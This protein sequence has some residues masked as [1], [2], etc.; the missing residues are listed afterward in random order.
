MFF[1]YT[2]VII[3]IILRKSGLSREE[4]NREKSSQ[5]LSLKKKSSLGTPYCLRSASFNQLWSVCAF[6]WQFLSAAI[7]LALRIPAYSHPPNCQTAV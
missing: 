5:W 4:N 7:S 1:L 2:C 3:R 6:Q